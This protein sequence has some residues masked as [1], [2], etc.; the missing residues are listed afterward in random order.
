MAA[1]R[2]YHSPKLNE[3]QKVQQLTAIIQKFTGAAGG[4]PGQPQQQQGA[5]AHP[6]TAGSRP[7]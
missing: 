4:R 2:I 7:G 5:A 6:A 3:T 1:R